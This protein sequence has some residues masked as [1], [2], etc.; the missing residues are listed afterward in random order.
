MSRLGPKPI[1]IP[2]NTQ[3][4]IKD[5]AV[6]CKGK[7]GE[8]TIDISPRLKVTK[9]D[10]TL[11]VE[12]SN[13]EKLSKSIHGVTRKLIM[14]AIE[15]V[16]NGYEKKLE[17]IGIGYRVKMNGK[18]LELSLGFSHP[19]IFD[20]PAG[21]EFKVVKNMIIISG[22]NKQLVGQIAADIRSLK[23]P[24]PYKGKGIKYQDEI[25]RRKTGKAAKA[26][27]AK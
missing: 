12:R 27:A 3:I 2:E 1:T 21:I 9:T 23:K 15:G 7:L 20:A 14:N 17:I 8:L 22:I 10:N 5:H 11:V 4:E 19:V 6:L 24:E 13:D 16:N 26:A 25:I 18:N